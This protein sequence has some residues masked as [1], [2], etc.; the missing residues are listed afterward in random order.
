MDVGLAADVLLG[1]GP[2]AAI[3]GVFPGFLLQWRGLLLIG[4]ALLDQLP[5]I[6]LDPAGDSL[7]IC[8][9]LHHRKP[10]G[11]HLLLEDFQAM[12][13]LLP[14]GQPS[15]ILLGQCIRWISEIEAGV[16]RHLGIAQHTMQNFQLGDAGSALMLAQPG[17][18]LQQLRSKKLR[19]WHPAVAFAQ[20]TDEVGPAAIDLCQAQGKSLSLLGHLL[21][22]PPAQVHIH[23]L[24]PSAGRTAPQRG[25]HPLHQQLTLLLEV[26]KRGREEH[27]NQPCVLSGGVGFV[28]AA[29]GNN[30]GAMIELRIR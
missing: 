20:Q 2:G 14:L 17:L 18:L 6:R 7:R 22:H 16:A 26:H 15:R 13:F 8:Q 3:V 27:T 11:S 5:Q 28:H 12:V 21:C 23:D 30:G 19:W 24:Y 1:A 25:K 10:T 4:E 29:A 9:A